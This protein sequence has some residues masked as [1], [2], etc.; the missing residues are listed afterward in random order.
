MSTVSRFWSEIEKIKIAFDGISFACYMIDKE[1]R[2]AEIDGDFSLKQALFE[3]SGDI[4]AKW[5]ANTD[6]E[7]GKV[8]VEE[9]PMPP[10]VTCRLPYITPG[11]ISTMSD[12]QIKMYWSQVMQT[13]VGKYQ[14]G[15][16]SNR[17][18]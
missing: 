9:G 14:L 5:M 10:G 1:S 2:I 6:A 7:E 11:G 12:K 3:V 13:V 4:N 18:K 15:Y 16:D 17:P 8:E